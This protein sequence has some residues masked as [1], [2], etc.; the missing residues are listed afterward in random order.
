[1][2]SIFIY[3]FLFR[4]EFSFGYDG[5]SFGVLRG[6][7]GQIHAVMLTLT[8]ASTAS[9]NATVTL[10]SVAF[11]VPLTNAG[12]AIPFSAY[13]V[14]NY[15]GYTNWVARNAGN[16]VIF[17]YSAGV[18][19]KSGTYTFSHASAVGTFATLTVGATLQTDWVY[20]ANFNTNPALSQSID[21][22]LGNIYE[23]SFSWLGYNSIR[24]SMF[25]V[26]VGETE[27]VHEIR[28][29]NTSATPS[30]QI[31][32]F[33][34]Q[35][36][37]ASLGSSTAM[38]LKTASMG[39]FTYATLQ[40]LANPNFT[41]NSAKA[42][43]A[44]TETILLAIKMRYAMN[45]IVINSSVLLDTISIA[46][47]GTKATRISLVL[48]PTTLSAS[49]T[50]NYSKWAYADENNSMV[51]TDVLAS[52]YTGGTIIASYYLAKSGSIEK[53][54][55]RGDYTLYR[56]DILLISAYST[57]ASDLN[58]SIAWVEQV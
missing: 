43:S 18:G 30:V 38:S 32:N 41:Y 26:A 4:S 21:K 55:E 28:Y 29:P 23:I 45:G 15:S 53:Q 49:T 42:I 3:L 33:P 27:V 12:G 52:T 36:S 2:N 10:N 35:F 7:G 31:P 48:N 19:A 39:A 6:Y 50:A 24:F 1:M 25:N 44:T 16:T 14:A 47:D 34:L 17:V 46:C 54:Y 40:R 9:T 56:D 58:A 57:G 37:C 11:T 5:T 8:S 20:E 22:Q 51:V 13:E